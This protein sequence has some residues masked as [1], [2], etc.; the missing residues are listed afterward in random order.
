MSHDGRCVIGTTNEVWDVDNRVERGA[1]GLLL[2][3]VPRSCRVGYSSVFSDGA[4][5]GAGVPSVCMTSECYSC[6]SI[7]PKEAR[8]LPGQKMSR[9]TWEGKR[10][11][12]AD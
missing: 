8:K 1:R 10:V 2:V 5:G 6:F 12:P 4:L 9:Y 7:S 3:S 11:Q